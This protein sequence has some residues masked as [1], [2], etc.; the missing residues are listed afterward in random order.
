M[1][2]AKG[3]VRFDY[4]LREE[5]ALPPGEQTVWHLKA[6]T[7]QE[8]EAVSE[9]EYGQGKDGLIL[10]RNPVRSAR[11]V[12]GLGLMGYDRFLEAPPFQALGEGLERGIAT[13]VLDAIGME[14]S[15]ELANA[16]T[17]GARL[18]ESTAKN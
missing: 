13:E 11:Q 10:I 12:L 14:E 17:N 18:E 6:L 4:V 5:R 8:R 9:V 15:I 7:W 3:I 2:K 16:I 1:A